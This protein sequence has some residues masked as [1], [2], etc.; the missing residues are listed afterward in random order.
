ML[1]GHLYIRA[2]FK[3][4]YHILIGDFRRKSPQI[5]FLIAPETLLT[6]WMEYE[7]KISVQ[8]LVLVHPVMQLNSIFLI[9]MLLY[10]QS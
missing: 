1:G 5:L 2:F 9:T 3:S 10:I 4:I 6:L 8:N 7:S